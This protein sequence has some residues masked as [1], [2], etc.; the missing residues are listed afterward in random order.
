MRENISKLWS[1]NYLLG[2][3]E[4]DILVWHHSMNNFSFKYLIRISKR[5]IIPRKL[6]RIRKLPPYVACIL[7]KYHKRPWRTKGKHSSGSIRKPPDA[8]PGAMASIDHMVSARPGLI[9]QVT[10]DPTHPRFWVSTVF[11]DH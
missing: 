3:E 1:I 4:R 10:G 2:R 5:G 11:V 6:I 7:G 8:R 9:T